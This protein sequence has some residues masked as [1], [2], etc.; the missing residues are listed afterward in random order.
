M[1]IE[2]IVRNKA[3]LIAQKK[4]VIKYADGVMGD[5]FTPELDKV[6][7]I[8]A[9]SENNDPTKLQVKAVIN[10][11]N[12]LDSHGDV[13]I[14]GLWNKSLKENKMIMHLQEHEMKFDKIISDG[15]DLKA[16]VK[17][18]SFKDLGYK[19]DGETQALVFDSTIKMERNKF[20]F[21]QYQKGI[22]KNHSV[23]M[24][25]VKL[26]LAVND[27]NYKE[28]FDIWNK[29]YSTIANKE[30]A[31]AQGYFWAVTEAKV[32]EGSAVPIGSNQVTPTLETTEAAKQGT[33]RH[34]EP[35]TDG[36]HQ[37]KTNINLLNLL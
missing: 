29:Y 20:M 13:H 9:D 15:K 37:D 12:V 33:S 34:T 36:T 4:A 8:K 14:K 35:P 25:Y 21:E 28:E 32:I 1:T 2:K 26:F 19:L 30:T 31:D 3:V 27:E 16:S 5:Y 24:R 22:V 6:L 11:T 18:Y 23:G 17:M 7:T 10:T